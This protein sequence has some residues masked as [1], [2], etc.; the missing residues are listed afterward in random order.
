MKAAASAAK[1][2]EDLEEE[3]EE[4]PKKNKLVRNMTMTRSS[5]TLISS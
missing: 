5:L 2:K 3:G 1:H 4:E